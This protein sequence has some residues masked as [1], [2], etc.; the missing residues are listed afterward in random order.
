[1]LSFFWASLYFSITCINFNENLFK[2]LISFFIKK[3]I[4][5][6]LFKQAG[7]CFISKTLFFLISESESVVDSMSLATW[8]SSFCEIVRHFCM[9]LPTMLLATMMS[10]AE[11]MTLRNFRW[12]NR[13]LWQK[14]IIINKKKAKIYI[15]LWCNSFRFT[16]R[17]LFGEWNYFF[18]LFFTSINIACLLLQAGSMW[19]EWEERKKS[20]GR[21]LIRLLFSHS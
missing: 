2:L 3:N 13:V 15:I 20:N 18:Y 14:Q 17:L 7:C 8:F 10:L 12:D 21:S 19:F 1:M 6:L 5:Y 9:R 11:S 4:F 16:E